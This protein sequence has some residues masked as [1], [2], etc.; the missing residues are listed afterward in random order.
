[1]KIILFTAFS[2][3]TF[4]LQAQTEFPFDLFFNNQTLRVDYHHIGNARTEEITLDKLYLEGIW[5]G[6]P[7]NN[8]LSAELGMYK[9]KVEDIVTNRLI[10]SKGFNSIFSEYTTIDA[11]I[12]GVKKTFHESVL[13]P[14]PKKPF[15]LTIEKRDHAHNL[16]TVFSR[17]IDPNDYHII[18]EK[19]G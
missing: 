5:A 18:K 10:Y 16:N 9:V 3:I 13:V 8:L 14:F 17:D 2:L 7:G 15:R 6:Y 4:I 12:K 19:A 1:M 11:A